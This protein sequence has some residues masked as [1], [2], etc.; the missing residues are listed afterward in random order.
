MIRAIVIDDENSSYEVIKYLISTLN[1][2][3]DIIGYF[4]SGESGIDAIID[5][6]P[7]LVFLDIEMPGM[8]GLQVMKMI[9]EMKDINLKVIVITAYDYFEYAQSSLRL[10]AKDILLKPIE[11]KQFLETIENIFEFNY[12]D[13]SLLNEIVEYLNENYGE[14]ILLNECS[15][16]FHAS[17]QHVSRLF[18]KYLNKSF[19]T[20][21]NEIRISKAKELFITTNRSIKEVA[22][23][24]GYNNLN[25][26]YKNFKNKIGITPKDFKKKKY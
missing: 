6:E 10:G 22:Y 7:N 8:N 23:E 25:Y 15:K 5:L 20:Y 18:R 9:K 11:K 4:D 19:T 2:P 3:I 16:K 12:T 14:T 21:L 26:F 1:L 17:P 13:N 24:V